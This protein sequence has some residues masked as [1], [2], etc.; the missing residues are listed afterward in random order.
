LLI[1]LGDEMGSVQS[2]E[3]VMTASNVDVALPLLFSTGLIAMVCYLRFNFKV[4]CGELNLKELE[5]KKEFTEKVKYHLHSNEGHLNSTITPV[6][7]AIDRFSG[8]D[9]TLVE[10]R[11]DEPRLQCFAEGTSITT[12]DGEVPVE[13]LRSGDVVHVLFGRRTQSIVSI[14][15]QTINCRRHPRPDQV[16]PVRI[17]AGA[18]GEGRPHREL[19]LSRNHC[20]LIGDVLIP[21]GCLENRTSVTQVPMDEIT[22]FHI[23]LREHD[24]IIAEG[25][26]VES[27]L[28]I[29][30]EREFINNSNTIL[31]HPNFNK[32]R[33][34]ATGCAPI[35]LTGE[36]V[37]HAHERIS[38]L[39]PGAMAAHKLARR[40]SAQAA[41][42]VGKAWNRRIS[43][44]T[45]VDNV[46]VMRSYWYKP[47]KWSSM[48]GSNTSTM[49]ADQTD[50]SEEQDPIDNDRD[51]VDVSKAAGRA[52]RRLGHSNRGFLHNDTYLDSLLLSPTRALD[53]FL[54][55]PDTSTILKFER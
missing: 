25:A 18:L 4:S 7:T 39:A 23:L 47:S 32:I 50:D 12:P 51:F 54:G 29:G 33:R 42:N 9:Q 44:R 15:R 40:F 46:D 19:Y 1:S 5:A 14:G 20:V 3:G 22:Y 37:I 52:K 49:P 16:W 11:T 8:V 27:Y 41:R 43:D 17:L 45:A 30:D 34:E 55:R 36:P 10:T 53:V 26:A 13:E 38:K 28:P 31:L 21:I 2:E 6:R 35:V 48:R 24:V